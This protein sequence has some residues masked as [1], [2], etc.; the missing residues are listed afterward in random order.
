AAVGACDLLEDQEVVEHRHAGAAVS[1]RHPHAEQ[2]QLGQLGHDFVRKALL[3][4]PAARV[5]ND[6]AR[7]EVA[8][9]TLQNALVLAQIEVH[10]LPCAG[11]GCLK[12]CSGP[13]GEY[14]WIARVGSAKLA[15]WSVSSGT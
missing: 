9:R 11:G 4:V 14:S 13:A 12:R 2:A 6:F 5:R 15:E 1:F 8:H 3:G 10:F 7:A